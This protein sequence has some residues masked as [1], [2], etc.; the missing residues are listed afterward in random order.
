MC[1]HAA[2]T[3]AAAFD[4][5]PEDLNVYWEMVNEQGIHGRRVVMSYEDD[6]Y[7]PTTARQAAEAC[8]AK[9]PF[10][11]VGGIGFDQIPAVRAFAEEKHVLY[12]HHMARQDYT[13][14]YSFS[15]LPTVEQAGKLAAQWIATQHPG[16]AV[17]ALYRNSENWEPG[18]TAFVQELDRLN[19]EFVG[20]VPVQSDQ[21]TY[22]T[23]L[24]TLRGDGA[25]VLFAWENALNVTN[26]VGQAKG[27]GWSPQW[28]VFPFNLE[29]DTLMGQALSPPLEGIA[30]WSAYSPGD[31][32]GPFA[33]YADEIRRFE[34]AYR[35]YR[36]NVRDLTDLHWQVWLAWKTV[37]QLF[38]SC[39]SDCT[40]NK[41]VG[42]LLSRKFGYDETKPD[43]PRDFTRNGHVGG[44]SVSFYKAYNGP[45]GAAWRHVPGYHCRES[46]V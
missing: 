33:E 27:Q 11:L 18:Y 28:V 15:A 3:Y 39:G 17:G 41:I 2:L 19:V 10:I 43:C 7:D 36:P 16:K 42:M 14:R 12:V 21:R 35:K 32:S 37:H 22:S 40:R 30:A 23:Q 45:N 46:L 1:G 26:M 8:L 9:D 31:Y 13:K 5:R 25:Q 20:G 38:V 24:N 34:A 4:T 6:A 44:F 29:T